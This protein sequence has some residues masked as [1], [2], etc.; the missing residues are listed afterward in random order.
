VN[1]Y[2]HDSLI[3][4]N[5]QKAGSFGSPRNP[6]PSLKSPLRFVIPSALLAFVFLP[7]L[8]PYVGKMAAP[9]IVVSAVSACI[10]VSAPGFALL[11]L[12][13]EHVPA[14]LAPGL[15][16]VGSAAGGW[17]LFW[18]WFANSLIG[19][20]A[21]IALSA[22]AMIT[23]SL[24]PVLFSHK[25]TL[26]PILASVM[27]CI[28]YLS[29]AGDRGGM[30]QGDRLIGARYWAIMDNEIPR[31]FADCLTKDRAGLKPFLL[32][33]WHSSDRPP[34][35]TGMIM[36]AYPLVEEAG[37]RL[38]YLLLGVAVNLFWIFG[39]WSFLRA[40]CIPEPRILLV[41]IMVAL[42]GAVFINTVYTWPKM[43]ST[44]L[45][46]T[47]AA[48]IFD[49]NCP[50]KVRTLVVG[51]ASAFSLLSHGSAAFALLGLAPLF[52]VR[53]KE[54]RTCEV[55]ATFAV[56]AFIYCPWVAYQRF[57]DPPGNRLIKWHLAG[58]VPLDESRP[59]VNT[60]VEAYHKI[61]L[62]GL[63]VNKLHNLRMLLGDPTDWNGA[64]AQGN[65]QPGWDLTFAGHVRHFFLLRLGPTP[66]LLL[67]GIPWLFTRRV[68]Q[69]AWLKPLAGVLL[70]TSLI[71]LLLEFGSTP[72]TTTWLCHTPYTLLILWC[73]LGAL[74]IGE[75]GNKWVFVF[76]LLHL[77]LFVCLWDYD[78]S[79]CSALQPPSNP[80][81]ADWVAMLISG[82]AALALLVLLLSLN[83]SAAQTDE[84]VVP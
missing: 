41:V 43:L 40:V 77:A 80:G 55:I 17:L 57:Y 79:M 35:Q 2:N 33:D 30:Q 61:G 36:I 82:F 78:V 6:R 76:L 42:V 13:G 9:L 8:Y 26:V 20:C 11:G 34:L 22:T 48:A 19:M 4:T 23:L 37:D 50:K 66:T 32:A 29:V 60:I 54:W 52:W 7:P 44:A 39:L 69:A 65:A 27:V 24:K 56:A 83:Q 18:A 73:A 46:L 70:T 68:R 14:S 59:A 84:T 12:A 16:V 81:K 75:M 21:S 74:A 45:L 1:L 71:Y 72:Q 5:E 3:G 15:V 47:A 28:G 10:L 31:M 62:S 67:I 49:Q 25:R 63:A 64:C 51:S 38:A 53:R 58:V